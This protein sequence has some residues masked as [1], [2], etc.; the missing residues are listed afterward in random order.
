MQEDVAE[1]SLVDMAMGQASTS[2]LLT[3]STARGATLEELLPL[4]GSGPL[5]VSTDS[6]WPL[7]WVGNDPH[8]WRGPWVW[9]ANRWD[10]RATLF[11][12]NDATEER[13]WGSVHTEVGTAVHAL[14]TVLSSLRDMVTPVGQV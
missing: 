6:S 13:K 4:E 14:T 10:T 9:W 1:A 3:P 2:V 12:L 5:G 11:T 7:V 8:A